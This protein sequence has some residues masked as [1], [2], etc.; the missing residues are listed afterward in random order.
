ML[1]KQPKDLRTTLVDDSFD[2]PQTY[3]I[4]V[5]EDTTYT[6]Q[7]SAWTASFTVDRQSTE[8]ACCELIVQA[9]DG[10]VRF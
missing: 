3:S 2:P 6:K 4:W 1:T 9:D 5:C 10:Q 7:L 8:Q